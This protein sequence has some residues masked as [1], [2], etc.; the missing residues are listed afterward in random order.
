MNFTFDSL[1]TMVLLALD[2]D[3]H[4][5]FDGGV[6]KRFSGE[7]YQQLDQGDLIG[8]ENRI[9][10]SF[11]TFDMTD[12]DRLYT[13]DRR[14]LLHNPIDVLG[15]SAEVATFQGDSLKWVAFYKTKKRP[16]GVSYL[17]KPAAW[18]EMHHKLIRDDG[19]SVYQK[20]IIPLDS[21]GRALPAK[22]QNAFVCSP[23]AEGDSV[24]LC[25]SLIEDAH[26][27]NTMLAEVKDS[28]TIKFPVP[29]NEYK[30][31]F[32]ARDEPLTPSGRKKAIVHWVAQHMRKKKDNDITAVKKHVRG[33]Q[34]ITVGGVSITITPN[35]V[36]ER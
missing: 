28:V 31:V 34:H 2:G 24:V 33:V 11:Y 9:P 8:L 10:Q 12:E 19:C 32:F 18:Y 35:D 17:G 13:T 3:K 27:P 5:P 23:D 29:I 21:Q 7:A 25:T 1:E 4:V 22:I 30:D 15:D 16:K 6:V 14:M 36:V 20:R 26:R